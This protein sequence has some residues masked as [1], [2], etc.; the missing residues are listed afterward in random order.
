[1]PPPAQ[2]PTPEQRT[3]PSSGDASSTPGERA[4][5]VDHQPVHRIR[6]AT[7]DPDQGIDVLERVYAV[8]R[9]RLADN[10]PFSLRQTALSIEHI[11]CERARLTGAPTAALI[12]ATDIVRVGQVLGGR[13]TF[14]DATEAVPTPA[15]FLFPVRPYA[16]RWDEID[17]QTVSM[18]L[19]ALQDHA[20]G[21]LD[22]D[23]FRLRFT[24]SAPLSPAMARYWTDTLTHFVR[25]QLGNG[26]AMAS[27]L[28]RNEAY[29][30]LATAL[31]H[32]F[33][34][35]FLDRN[36]EPAED[37][38]AAPAVRRAVAFMEEHLAEDIA[39]PEIAAA[40]RMSPRGLQAAFRRELGTTPSAHLRALRLEAA[41]AD[42]LAAD[43][44]TGDTVQE[45]AARWGFTHTGRFAG[46]YRTRYG[47]NPTTTLRA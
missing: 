3:S 23:D 6:V 24:G 20:A 8:R 34:S 7:D 36:A 43:L 39:L 45:I 40:A 37:R 25:D 13:L 35:T 19:S 11:S 10:A 14:T 28:A 26:E 21:L 44:T 41:H 38:P 12:D 1:M 47:R 4:G 32:A 16:C 31:L 17:L 30:S 22:V 29:R 46:A 9:L 5:A 2:P 42:L 33:P 27:P 18:E 15:P